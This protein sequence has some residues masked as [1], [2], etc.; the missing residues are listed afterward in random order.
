[1]MLI[2]PRDLRQLNR[3]PM[4]MVFVLDCSGS[5]A[6]QPIEQAKAAIR[7]GLRWL[8]PGDS[9]QI[10]NF[11]EG[12]SQLGSAPL[13]ATA[14]NVQR[15]MDYVAALN[16]DGPT[17]MI[18]GVKAALNF[19]HDPERLRFVCFLTDGYIGN[20]AQIL[21]AVHERIGA[22][23]IFTVGVGSS[24]NRYLL[25]HMAKLG[26]GA[27]ASLGLQDDAAKVMDDFFERVSHPA[28]TD[29]QVDW[30][31]LRASEIYPSRVPDLF[32]GRPVIL[33]GRFSGD[34]TSVRVTG[35]AAGQQITFAVPADSKDA[36]DGRALP[37]IWAR[38]KIAE[39]ADQAAYDSNPRL[40][41]AMKQLALDYGLM[42]TFTAF[43]AVDST[44][45]TEGTQGVTVPV[46][47]PVPK[48][49]N[50]DNTV[51][52]QEKEKQ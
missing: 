46:P 40:P 51:Q 17:E 49:V 11:S 33:T 50:Y 5:M 47:V 10:I 13:D 37:K 30:G 45:T 29:I 1:M 21:A 27:V 23:R 16:G 41:Q 38:S 26:R 15:G 48:G 18:E 34:E 2:P 25:D 35:N 20:E 14:E 24:P 52:N 32:V 6:G 3:A 43:I 9:F 28:L 12:A 39:L 42:S 22:S 19:Q 8:Q 7:Q 44:R 36:N 4:E 31:N